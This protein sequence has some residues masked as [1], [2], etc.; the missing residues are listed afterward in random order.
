MI[1]YKSF[2]VLFFFIAVN[3]YS[4]RVS[5][6]RKISNFNEKNQDTL[7]SKTEGEAYQVT[8]SKIP[9]ENPE[10]KKNESFPVDGVKNSNKRT[11][12]TAF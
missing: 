7:K 8:S 9:I 4:Q 1:K 5:M 10:K 2:F 12:K 11:K 6:D 3:V